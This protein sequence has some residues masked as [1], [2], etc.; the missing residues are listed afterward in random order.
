MH[1]HGT[2]LKVFFSAIFI[3]IAG[4][5]QIKIEAQPAQF[6]PV[7]VGQTVNGFQDDF[8]GTTRDPNWVSVGADA[9]LYSLN[10]GVLVI[11]S[12]A[13]DPNHLLYEAA[14][15]DKVVQE[16]LA[17]MKVT[18]FEF[19]DSGVTRGGIGVGSDPDN[20]RPGQALNLHFRDTDAT[21]PV[22]GRH[23][24]LLDDFK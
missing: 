6:T 9:D 22:T 13:G 2:S 15:Y 16:V 11:P 20:N 14:G 12:L 10:N 8:T 1:T 3:V 4:L 5:T 7:D 23:V 24:G 18:G 17:R 19:S 21:G